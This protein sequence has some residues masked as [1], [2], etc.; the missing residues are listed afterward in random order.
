MITDVYT[1]A[2]KKLALERYRLT[3]VAKHFKIDT[4]NA[5]R[6]IGDCE[7]T[8]ECFK[9]LQ[10]IYKEDLEYRKAHKNED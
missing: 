3:D 5:H 7:T 6:A 2:R 1:M 8:F 9:K 10:K 4:S